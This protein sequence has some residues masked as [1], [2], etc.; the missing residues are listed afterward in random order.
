MTRPLLILALLIAALASQLPLSTPHAAQ[1]A[2]FVWTLSQ[3]LVNPRN[4]PTELIG[5]AVSGRKQGTQ[6]EWTV[7]ETSI[8]HHK[9]EV[10]NAYDYYDVTWTADFDRPP[11]VLKPGDKLELTASVSGSG[12]V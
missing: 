8:S 11:T 4:E 6:V 1:Q 10:D 12:K 2:E 9:H 5:A 3:T 7:T